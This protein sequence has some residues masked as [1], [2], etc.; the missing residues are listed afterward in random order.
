MLKTTEPVM[1]DRKFAAME[2]A[3][4]IVLE[5]GRSGGVSFF[6]ANITSRSITG[7]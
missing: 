2:M 6:V 3:V 7:S 1:R 5:V 4:T